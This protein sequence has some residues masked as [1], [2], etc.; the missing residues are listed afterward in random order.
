M[1]EEGRPRVVPTREGYDLWAPVYDTEGNP[2]LAL[3]EP[4]VG[5]A[6]GDVRGLDVLAAGRA[7]AAA[8]GWSSRPARLSFLRSEREREVRRCRRR[9]SGSMRS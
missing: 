8:A 9:S 2:L 3:E 7:A 4:E 5:R 1:S 6:L